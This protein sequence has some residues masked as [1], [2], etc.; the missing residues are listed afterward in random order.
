MMYAVIM[1]GGQGTRFWPKSTRTK[2]KQFLSI[3][4]SSSMLTQTA[5]RLRPL[6]S[7]DN[8]LFIGNADHR[9]LAQQE[10]ADL[11]AHNIISEPVG[12][13]TAPCLGLACIYLLHRD[14]NA[15]VVAVPADHYIKR[16]AVFRTSI[17]KSLKIASKTDVVVTIG[18]RPD[19]PHPGYGYIET[20]PTYDADRSFSY[21]K[22]FVEKPD[23]RRARQYL[24]KGNFLWNSGIFVF[25]ADLMLELFRIYQPAMYKHLMRIASAIGTRREKAVLAGEFAKLESI[26][27]DYAIMEKI[28]KLLITS[29]EFGWNDVGSWGTLADIARKDSGGNVCNADV[30]LKNSS[31][32]I[33][34]A[35]DKLI[36]LL[37]VDDL[38]VVQTD[39]VVLIT[40]KDSDQNVKSLVSALKKQGRSRFL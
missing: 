22:Q 17:K 21:V 13:N 28:D 4:G 29:G 40:K 26:S 6:I 1:G 8:T 31:G 20:G 23:R 35:K 27:I 32:N 33:I 10:L 11:P 5:E 15:T 39:D 30:L 3:I 2:P 24:Q 38:I 25:R 37:D 7:A 16:P 19:S 34:D 14:K 18:I 36:A 9:K 12:R